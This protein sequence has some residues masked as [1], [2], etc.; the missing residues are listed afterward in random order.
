MREA[1]SRSKRMHDGACAAMS[2]RAW[3]ARVGCCALVA[4][5][6]LSVTKAHAVEPGWAGPV[7][8]APSPRQ[9][10]SASPALLQQPNVLA[11]GGDSNTSSVLHSPWF[12]A[13]V[14]GV[15]VATVVLT[16]ALSSDDEPSV[17]AGT[18]SKSVNVL[19]REPCGTASERPWR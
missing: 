9:T 5:L 10:A 17:P 16:L 2:R 7:A 4:T 3:L 13:G 18:L 15:V 14:A 8:I 19:T 12:W 11:A 6:V 1:G